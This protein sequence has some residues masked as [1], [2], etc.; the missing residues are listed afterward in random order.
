MRMHLSSMKDVSLSM[1]RCHFPPK[2][3]ELSHTV[4]GSFKFPLTGM[5]YRSAVYSK[6]DEILALSA[7]NHIRY[8]HLHTLLKSNFKTVLFISKDSTRFILC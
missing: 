3:D 8:F 2:N 4:P 7:H 5:F 1:V 6:N